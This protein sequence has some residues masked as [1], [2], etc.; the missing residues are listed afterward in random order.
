M[1][2]AVGTYGQY[3]FKQR[4]DDA[5][6][7]LQSIPKVH[8]HRIATYYVSEGEN[9]YRLGALVQI[10]NKNAQAAYVIDGIGYEGGMT[11]GGDDSGSFTL[12]NVIWN[13]Q[14]GKV[15]GKYYLKA[16]DETTIKFLLPHTVE[17]RILGGVPK[18]TFTGR[19]VIFIEG[20]AF[21]IKPD[22]VTVER[23][24]SASEWNHL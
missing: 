17:M 16:G 8:I 13:G 14:P 20:A 21:Q 9:R 3:Y 24:I 7:T 4:I 5:E 15:T 11:F 22:A 19:W 10:L 18:V 6:K 1:L 2:A 23:I 12:R